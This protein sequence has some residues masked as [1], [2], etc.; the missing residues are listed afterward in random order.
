VSHRC[1]HGGKLD[2]DWGYGPLHYFAP[3]ARL[4]GSEGLKRLVDAAHA[5]N[6]TVILDVVYEHVDQMFPYYMVYND[7]ANA[8]GTPKPL[9]P[10]IRGWNKWGF[11]PAADFTQTFTR[12]YFIAANRMWL[13]DYHVD[14]FRYDEV[15][16]LY[17]PPRAAG[18]AQLVEETYRYS[19]L[20]DRFQRPT[21]G[22]SR[23]I[24]CA[25]ALTKSRDVLRETFT[26]RDSLSFIGRVSRTPIVRVPPVLFVDS[27]SLDREAA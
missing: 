25:E 23:I 24:Q 8:V 19:L 21:G 1:W 4:G 16:D 6:I 9:S 2:F 22:F 10:M 27:V 13:D 14:G 26:T 5:Q 12:E 3:S 17:E 11:G 15:T 18:Y 7:I 20:L